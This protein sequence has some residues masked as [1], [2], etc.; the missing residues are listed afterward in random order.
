VMSLINLIK[1][2]VKEKF[3]VDLEEEIKFF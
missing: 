3:L 2:T 1:K